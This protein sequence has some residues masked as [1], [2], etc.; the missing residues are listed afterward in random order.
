MCGNPV[1]VRLL[2][3]LLPTTSI[4][5]ALYQHPGQHEPACQFCHCRSLNIV[6]LL[7]LSS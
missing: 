7:L 1:F 3:E 6:Q 4:L 5:M 2:D